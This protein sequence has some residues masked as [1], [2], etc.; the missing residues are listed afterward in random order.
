[1][2]EQHKK[3]LQRH[4][5]ENKKFLADV[6]QAENSERAAIR[7]QLHDFHRAVEEKEKIIDA[8]L[9]QKQIKETQKFEAQVDELQKIIF[10]K[11][12]TAMLQFIEKIKGKQ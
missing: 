6:L 1:M 12:E 2:D 10:S 5:D 9:T 3:E 11:D 4:I 7:E 8:T